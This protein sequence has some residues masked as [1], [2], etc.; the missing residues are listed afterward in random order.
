MR[1][2]SMQDLFVHELRDLY[3]AETQ[4]L[5]ALPKMASGAHDAELRKGFETHLHETQQ[6][7]AR[8]EDIFSAMGEN[9]RGLTCK[10]MEGLIEEASEMLK[11]KGDATVLDAGI[12]GSASRVEHYE[13]AG[14]TFAHALAMKLGDNRSADL[15]KASLAEETATEKK[16]HTSFEMLASK[17][18]GR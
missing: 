6:Q 8:I 16:L 4:L 1:L 13:I 7:V 2:D 18:V 10:A 12:I 14:Y 3:S 11:E 17:S 5:K 9:P 15:L